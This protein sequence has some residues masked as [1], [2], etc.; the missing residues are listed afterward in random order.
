M[1]NEIKHLKETAQELK[2]EKF[3]EMRKTIVR[4]K[5]GD[6]SVY[7]VEVDVGGKGRTLTFEIG[8]K[9][10]ALMLTDRDGNIIEYAKQEGGHIDYEE[11]EK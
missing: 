11:P 8:K 3:S 1:A 6:V 9:Y 2:E 10:T 4:T 7:S 5:D